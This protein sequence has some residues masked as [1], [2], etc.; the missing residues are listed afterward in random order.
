MTEFVN[1]V[2]NKEINYT[3]TIRL[4]LKDRVFLLSWVN[5]AHFR[6]L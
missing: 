3:F 5:S 6:T 4:K 2:S 1:I